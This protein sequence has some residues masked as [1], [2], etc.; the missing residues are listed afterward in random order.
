MLRSQYCV[1]NRLGVGR[2]SGSLPP[3]A[4][5]FTDVAVERAAKKWNPVFRADARSAL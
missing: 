3:A 5:R 2:A 4:P 1:V